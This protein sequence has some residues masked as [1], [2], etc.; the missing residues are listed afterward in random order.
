[1]SG[2]GT[3]NE[4][5]LH[6]SLKEWLARP[7]DLFEV[8]LDG[9]FIDIVRGKQLL[10][11]QTGSF[12]SIRSKLKKLVKTHQV[13]LIYPIAREKWI[14]KLPKVEGDS[15]ERRKS[16]KRGDV[17]DLFREMVSFPQL[18]AHPNF[19]LQILLIREEELR[20]H[21]D[22]GGWRR[23]GWMTVEHRLLEVLE[24]HVFEDLQDWLAL[25]PDQ[26][27]TP[28]STRDLAET[29][30]IKQA[31]A[32]RMVYCLNKADVIRLIGKRGR[33]LLYEINP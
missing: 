28:F 32:Q 31:Q 10:E 1:M 20:L 18:M 15:E 13:Q 23:R 19:S 11:I 4:K 26:L 17:L 6:A 9:F 3:L 30:N 33:F 16:P 27:E 12:A 21:N 8:P 29:A 25:L 14:V 2:I 5:P 24:Q 7:G 22:T